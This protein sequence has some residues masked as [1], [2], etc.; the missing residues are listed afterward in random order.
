VPD[1]RLK[2]GVGGQRCRSPNRRLDF[3]E[4]VL[5]NS[6]APIWYRIHLSHDE[7]AGGELAILVGAFREVFVARN[8]PQGMALFGM[9][10]DDGYWVYV[11]PAAVRYV[12]PLLEAYSA[13]PAEPRWVRAL[14]FLSGD[15]AGG[16]LLIC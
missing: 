12:R 10:A 3:H 15:E 14:D 1:N 9:P 13:Q 5:M 2:A 6:N 4:K 8:G 16:S 11:T 7:Y